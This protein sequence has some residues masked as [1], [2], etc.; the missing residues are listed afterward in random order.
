MRCNLKYVVLNPHTD[1]C[2]NAHE[3]VEVVER[4]GYGHLLS[5][6]VLQIAGV[7][8]RK[9]R[10][11][12]ETTNK[13]TNRKFRSLPI[14][15]LDLFT[16]LS[17]F[18]TWSWKLKLLK[19]YLLYPLTGLILTEVLQLQFTFDAWSTLQ[20]SFTG[21]IVNFIAN[22]DKITFSSRPAQIHWRNLK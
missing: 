6:T 17:V 3:L 12:E 1:K 2:L 21:S 9:F 10:Y 11:K 16:L 5:S 22:V 15:P 19:S 20:K 14:L 4:S 7:R 18:C 8:Q 13:R